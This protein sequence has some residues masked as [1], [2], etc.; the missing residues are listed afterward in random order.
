MRSLSNITLEQS[1]NMY[2]I[3]TCIKENIH[4]N[5]CNYYVSI[6]DLYVMMRN[7]YFTVRV[8]A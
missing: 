8:N 2:C 6:E 7:D 4:L 3:F 5:L 1:H